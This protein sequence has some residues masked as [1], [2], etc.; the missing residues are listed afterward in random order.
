MTLDLIYST[1]LLLALS[2]LYEFNIRAWGQ[3]MRAARVFSGL[4]F[5]AICIFGMLHP[6]NL[7]PGV[8]FDA[9]SVILG[10]A[11]IFGGPVIAVIAGLM[12]G[13]YRLWLGGS[14]ALV[15]VAV[16]TTSVLFGLAMRHALHR[17]WAQ[18][19]LL[20]FLM[21]GALLHLVHLG[22]FLLLPTQHLQKLLETLAF[23]Y[24]FV[25]AP[26]TA[27]LAMLL[28]DLQEQ[29]QAKLALARSE[30]LRLAITR[31]SPDLLFVMDEEG[32]Y[33]EIIS[34]EEQLLFKPAAETLG[35]RLDEV[36]PESEARRFRE[37]MQQTLQAGTPQ[38]I[39]YELDTL[40]GRHVFE[41]RAQALDIRVEGKR[42]VVFVARDITERVKAE[43][44]RRVAAVAFESRQAMLVS[45]AG[46]VILRVNQA[47]VD[48]MGY[49]REEVVGRKT[50]SLRSGRHDAAFYQAMWESVRKTGKWEGE[51]WDQ[52]KRGDLI[53]LWTTITAVRDVH[54][55]V[56]N[57]VATM[58][59]ISERKQQEEEIRSIAFYD[60]LTALPNRRLLLERLQRALTLTRRNGQHGALLFVDVDNFKHINDEH[61]HHMGDLLLQEIA[62]RLGRVVR[63]SDTVARI[64]GDEFVIVLEHLNEDPTLARTE[65]RQIA[66]KALLAMAKPYDLQGLIY[67]ASGS[68]GIAMFNQ[69]EIDLD[70]LMRQADEAMY[71]AKHAGKN[72]VHLHGS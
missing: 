21:F 50:N 27:L 64:G 68:I 34:P 56:T 17:G 2:A 65:A 11:G 18:P 33:L 66:A 9:R 39:E 6:A 23:P 8:I 47:F 37:F 7:A 59:D 20:D 43:Q 35:K 49:S 4:I 70:L 5:G 13:A 41:G 62:S 51:L 25:L 61:G 36:L 24:L 22:W 38:M 53:P 46:T 45:D 15:G 54:G 58:N 60:P 52:R 57:Y 10:V 1:T 69:T 31:A 42:A 12:A 72:T 48:L 30:A 28:Q 3:R 14:G 44:D 55:V 26:S 67:H 40:G 19:K 16:I 32:R 29:R 71:Q 63:E